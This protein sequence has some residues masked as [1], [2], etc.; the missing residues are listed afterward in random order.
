M[1]LPVKDIEDVKKQTSFPTAEPQSLLDSLKRELKRKEDHLQKK[2]TKL[3][4][5][6]EE[7]KA[8]TQE[9]GSEVKPFCILPC[10]ASHE[11]IR[12]SN[13]FTRLKKKMMKELRD[14]SQQAV[15]T[16]YISG[17][18]GSGKSQL[19]QELFYTR[20]RDSDDLVFVATLNAES[21]ETLA[22]S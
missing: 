18:P 22:N 3:Q 10:E 11:V 14:G 6:E 5:K 1:G 20:S 13:D 2:Y 17:T 4:S 19:G 16:I 9:I 15:S 7:V 12:R 8:L 21:V